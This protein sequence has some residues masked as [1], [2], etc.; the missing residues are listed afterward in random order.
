MSRS[1]GFSSDAG[2]VDS[3]GAGSLVGARGSIGVGAPSVVLNLLPA[4]GVIGA[5]FGAH[6]LALCC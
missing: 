3:I 2:S 6:S 5:L 1:I 4:W